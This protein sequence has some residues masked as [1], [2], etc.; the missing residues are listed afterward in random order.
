MKELEWEEGHDVLAVTHEEAPV[1]GERRHH[2]GLDLVNRCHRFEGLSMVRMHGHRHPLLGFRDEDLPWGK[3]DLL[4][5]GSRE[6]NLNA[7]GLLRHFA[8]R[9]RNP[10]CAVV[11]DAGDQA[12]VTCFQQHIEHLLLRDGVADLHRARWGVF[13]Q[14]QRGKGRAVNAVGA[15]PPADHVDQVA[16]LCRL[17]MPWTAVRKRRGHQTNRAAVHQRLADVTVVEHDGPI[18]RRDARFVAAHTHAG[19]DAT[20]HAARVEE[21]GGEVTLPIGWAEAEHVGVRDGASAQSSP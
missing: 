12:G 11:G 17:R 5:G 8:N 1:V 16:R 6:V 18:D 15:N 21:V 2:G 3:P 4:E 14:L 13:G 19:M 7:S 10:A 20:Q 9:G